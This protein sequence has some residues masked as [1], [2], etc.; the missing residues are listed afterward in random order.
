MDIQMPIM[1]GVEATQF[2]RTQM[3]SPKK[4]IKIIAMT[5]NVFK[6]D[7]ESYIAAGMNDFIGKPFDTQTLISKISKHTGHDQV[8]QYDAQ[9]QVNNSSSAKKYS[10]L[11]FLQEFTKQDQ[12]KLKKYI[13]IFLENA[14]KMLSQL[15]TAW[16][17]QNFDGVKIAAHSLKSQLKTMGVQEEDSHIQAIEFA[18]QNQDHHAHIPN[19]LH[20]LELICEHVF[21]ELKE[22]L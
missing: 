15:K 21:S 12:V 1:N 10:D 14:P 8:H 13:H 17:D 6:E 2:I 11:T 5:A 22:F 7:I 9:S 18:S 20:K 4:D 3:A 16:A 19:L